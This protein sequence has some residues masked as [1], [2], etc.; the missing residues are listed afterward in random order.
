MTAT[1]S[2]PARRAAAPPVRRRTV[3]SVTGATLAPAVP[4][5]L[6]RATGTELKVGM[7]GQAMHLAVAAVLVPGLRGTAAAGRHAA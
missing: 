1:T 6:S 2:A 5:L 3:L 4:W 7:S